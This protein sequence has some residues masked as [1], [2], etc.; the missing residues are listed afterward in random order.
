MKKNLIGLLAIVFAVSAAA[1]TTPTRSPVVLIFT[2]DP[3]TENSV[4]TESLWVEGTPSGCS[5]SFNNYAC[6]I[7]VD[8][9]DVTTDNP[10]QLDPSVD[11]QATFVT[12]KGYIPSSGQSFISSITNRVSD[13]N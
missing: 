3:A 1:F 7:T 4:K 8:S 12:G 2:G 6:T 5:S 13:P 9:D 10:R 11:L